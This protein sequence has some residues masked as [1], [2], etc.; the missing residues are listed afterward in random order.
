MI[1]LPL[2]NIGNSMDR[3]VIDNDKDSDFR[4]RLRTTYV[5]QK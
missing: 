3:L 2:E 1:T 4:I 5:V